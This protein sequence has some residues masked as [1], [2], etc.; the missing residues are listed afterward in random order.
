MHGQ[1]KTP[2]KIKLKLS[3]ELNLK[4]KLISASV[5]NQ[6]LK[7]E[8]S[9]SLKFTTHILRGNSDFT[10]RSHDEESDVEGNFSFSFTDYQNK[11]SK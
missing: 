3:F 10:S 2:L 1:S 6:I 7:S 11:R 9:F 4:Q 8:L 5:W